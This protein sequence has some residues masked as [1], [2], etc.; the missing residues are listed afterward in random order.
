[1]AGV[2]DRV[3]LVTGAGRGIGRE[4]ATL[5]ASRGARV[6]CVA[7]SEEELAADLADQVLNVPA[8]DRYSFIF[9]GNA[10]VLD[11]ALTSAGLVAEIGEVVWVASNF[12]DP[13]KLTVG[14]WFA[15]VVTGGSLQAGD[16]AEEAARRIAA[17]WTITTATPSWSRC[18]GAGPMPRRRG[19]S[20]STSA[21]WPSGWRPGR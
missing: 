5:L 10:Q 15:G 16:D 7:R 11:H 12:H 17:A 3:T 4:T 1:M 9:G 13:A 6:M 19:C 14:I 8:D 21:V 18:A 2:K 20:T